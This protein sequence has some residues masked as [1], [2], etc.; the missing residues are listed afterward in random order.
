ML[1]RVGTGTDAILHCA[2]SR[3][4]DVA[5]ARALGIATVWVNRHA[6][7]PDASASGAG[8]A[9]PDLEVPD[10][11]TLADLASGAPAVRP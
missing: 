7:R 8:T 3:F 2:E 10:M 4:H 11:K 6:G 9:M 5:P 1:Q